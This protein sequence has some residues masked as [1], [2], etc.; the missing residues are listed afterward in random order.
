MNTFAK[1][2]VLAALATAAVPFA[3]ATP[4]GTFTGSVDMTGN[5]DNVNG[6]VKNLTVTST[7]L[8]LSF[9]TPNTLFGI[10]DIPGTC[11]DGSPNLCTLVTGPVKFS[12]FDTATLSA[13]S[14]TQVFTDGTYSFEATGSYGLTETASDR[15][16]VNLTGYFS[17]PGYANDYNA[18]LSFQENGMGDNFTEDI[19]AATPEPSSLM[20][21]GTGLMSS[22]GMLLRR[23][24]VA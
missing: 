21:L 20:L 17:G 18:T 6:P 23:R 11:S 3:S 2:A 12:G 1:L 10:Y 4:L 24:K 8:T 22:A 7:D 14:P 19:T 9:G 5:T 13:S 15:G 16:S